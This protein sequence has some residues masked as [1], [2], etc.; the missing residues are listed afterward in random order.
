MREHFGANRVVS[1]VS[2]VPSFTETLRAWGLDP[3]ACTRYCEQPDLREVG[4]TKNPD[5]DRIAALEPRLVLLDKEENRRED[6]AELV[7]RGLNVFVTDIRSVW[8]VAPE[9]DRLAEALGLRSRTSD[10]PTPVSQPITHRAFVPIWRRPWMTIGAATYGSS[11]LEVLGIGNIF[12]GSASGAHEGGSGEYPEID[13]EEVALRRPDVILVPSEPYD[14]QQAHLGELSEVAPVVQIDGRDL[15]WWG[16]R[17][18][19]AIERLGRV[20]NPLRR[21]D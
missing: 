13:F 17:T 20:L 5:I 3:L 19:A 10:W 9:L 14:F 16:S 8:E 2:L 1:V 18:P 6:A 21:G 15:F 11:L 7:D 12:A 4:G